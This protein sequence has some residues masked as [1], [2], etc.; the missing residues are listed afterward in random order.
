MKP[1]VICLIY[2]FF[3]LNL[4][5]Q[6][7]KYFNS[8]GVAIKGYDPVAYFTSN[9]AVLGYDSISTEWSGS[10][11]KFISLE[12]QQAFKNKPTKYAP[13]YG[14]YCAYGSSEKHLSPTDPTAFTIVNNKLY[15]NY[16]AKVKEIWIK[17]TSNRIVAA[18]LYWQS[19][20]N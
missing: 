4:S 9:K 1:F 17:D 5:A 3:A 12:N 6:N 8:N 10:V 15:L 16:N 11:W 7:G 20:K 2:L 14:G 18:D 19:L 13:E